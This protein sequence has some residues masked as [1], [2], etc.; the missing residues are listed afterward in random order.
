MI[1]PGCNTKV[2]RL[3]RQL[4]EVAELDELSEQHAVVKDRKTVSE[5]IFCVCGQDFVTVA[6]HF[7]LGSIVGVNFEAVIA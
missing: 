2:E 3:V 5:K 6:N 1:C 4:V 7:T